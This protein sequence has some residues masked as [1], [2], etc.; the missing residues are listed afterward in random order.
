MTSFSPDS[1]ALYLIADPDFAHGSL[2]DTT[3]EAVANG[4]TMVQ[5]RWKSGTDRQLAEVGRA[6]MPICTDHHVPLIVNDRVDIALAIGAHGVHLGVDDLAVT[7]A[8]RIGGKQFI[9]GFSPDTDDQISAAAYD[10]ASYLGIGPLYATATKSD[11]GPGLGPDE[12]SRRVG[13]TPLP[14]VAIG[15]ITVD[16]AHAALDAGARGVAVISA[17]LGSETPGPAALA[18]RAAGQTAR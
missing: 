14:V 3:R 15:G 17:I 6:L 13:L 7:D 1:L 10:G 2:I 18:L 9:V 4:V 16:N 8:R 12:F 5:L 11:A